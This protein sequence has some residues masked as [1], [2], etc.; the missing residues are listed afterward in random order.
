[1]AR[2]GR[3]KRRRRRLGDGRSLLV[4]IATCGAKTNQPAKQ[5]TG[6]LRSCQKRLA[7]SVIQKTGLLHH[8]QLGAKL[9][10]RAPGDIQ[11][12]EGIL[13]RT[14]SRAFGDVRWNGYRRAT[15]LIDECEVVPDRR[16][17]HDSIDFD[18]EGLGGLPCRKIT[19]TD[20][21]GILLGIHRLPMVEKRS[22]TALPAIT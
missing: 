5:T 6:L 17:I 21:L 10:Q 20:H 1:M 2:T 12:P 3:T 18:R 4:V 22:P 8:L 19:I 16:D 13:I 14:S 7:D 11:E 15:Q 9:T